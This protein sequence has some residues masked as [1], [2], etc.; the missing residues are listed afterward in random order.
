MDVQDA[1]GGSQ[2]ANWRTE[3]D[4]RGGII[5]VSESTVAK[6]QDGTPFV[7][8]IAYTWQI[9]DRLT[10]GTELSVTGALKLASSNLDFAQNDCGETYNTTAKDGSLK[11]ETEYRSSMPVTI[12]EARIGCDKATGSVTGEAPFAGRSRFRT[13][14]PPTGSLYVKFVLFQESSLLTVVYTYK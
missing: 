3:G 2:Y 13:R 9:P 14:Q 6:A 1:V 10:P 7:A 11:L 12:A 8:R 5:S 4:G